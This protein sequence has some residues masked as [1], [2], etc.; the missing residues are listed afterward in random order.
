MSYDPAWIHVYI[1]IGVIVFACGGLVFMLRE[2]RKDVMEVKAALHE[3]VKAMTRAIE[4]L[5]DS[6]G[7]INARVAW[8]EG[9]A[10][11]AAETAQENK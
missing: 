2:M 9:R 10:S 11:K 4:R 7:K 1:Q 5:A 6:T 8:L 3:D